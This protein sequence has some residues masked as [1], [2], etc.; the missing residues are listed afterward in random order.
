[1]TAIWKQNTPD[2]VPDTIDA[3]AYPSV[4]A[5]ASEAIGKY[6]EATAF[7]NFGANLTYNDIDRLSRDLAAF[8]KNDLGLKKGDRVA[9]M[10]PNTFAFPIAMFA[11]IRSGL[12]QVNVNP[13]YTAR[14]LEHQL[15]DADTDTIIIFNGATSVLADVVA[16]TK[17]K[18]IITAD[19]GD[20]GNDKLPSLPVDERLTNTLSLPEAIAK[21]EG[22]EFSSPDIAG[23]D[24]LFLQYTGGTTGLSKGAALTHRNLVANI[25]QFSIAMGPQFR[26]HEEIV[27]TAL[28]LYHI[29]ALTVNCLSFFVK[30][31]INVLI[32]NPGDMPGFVAELGRWKFTAITGVNTL[33]N[34]LLHTPGFADLDFSSLNIIGGGGTAIQAAISDKWNEVTG[35]HIKEGYG[36]SET[37]PVL[38]F[39][40]ETEN[41]FT[42]T[43]GVPMPSTEISLRDEDGKEVPIGEPGELC[44]KGPQVMEG[45]WRKPDATA[46]VTTEDGFFKTGDVAVLT[47]DGYFKIVDRIKDMILVSGFNVFPNEIEG[48]VAKMDGVMEAACIGVP[49]E[50]T[51]EAVKLFVVRTPGSEVSEKDVTD[52]CRGELTGYKVPK[53]IAFIEALPKSAVGKILR[54]ELRDV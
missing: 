17:I 21:G 9:V 23:D 13:Q 43:I 34:G 26:E 39:N 46:D 44:A 48:V 2:Y 15:N 4:W 51:D 5:M 53:Q 6:G 28:P 10:C 11:N 19:L 49:D 45:Y 47:E 29:F 36:L 27:V 3:D 18:N 8:L 20:C 16:N 30:G 38:T 1:M 52:F 25:F 32:T 33:F 7:S 24:L 35:K 31:G 14:E 40:I 42:E 22:K 41:V 54:R 12:V 50:R 37:S